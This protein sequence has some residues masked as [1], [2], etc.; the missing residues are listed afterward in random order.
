LTGLIL[1]TGALQAGA[2]AAQPLPE[3]AG[4]AVGTENAPPGWAW[5]GEQGPE[6]MQMKGGERIKTNADSMRMMASLPKINYG[7]VTQ[8]MQTNRMALA[9]GDSFFS[10]GRA[11]AFFNGQESSIQMLA[12]IHQELKKPFR[13]FVVYSDIKDKENGINQ[14]K[15]L[16]GAK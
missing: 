2:V 1:A 6:L 3:I 11:D 16:S 8:A 7:A 13:G 12:A 15:N 10:S 4:Y 14:V 9:G 5:V